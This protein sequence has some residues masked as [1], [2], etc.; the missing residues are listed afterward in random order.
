MNEYDVII[1]Y[2]G[3]DSETEHATEATLMGYIHKCPSYPGVE[4][5][6]VV[7]AG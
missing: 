7:K 6:E 5:F 1:H 3:G 4:R 2:A